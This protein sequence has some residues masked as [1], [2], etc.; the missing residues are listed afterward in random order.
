M[1]DPRR[2]I[3]RSGT[4]VALL[5]AGG[6]IAG[7]CAPA[8]LRPL[9]PVDARDALARI[10]DNFERIRGPL[11]GS[12]ARISAR[13]RDQ[14][15]TTRRFTGYDA[16]LIFGAPRCLYL[17]IKHPAIGSVARIGSND[18]RYWL[19]IDVDDYRNLM[20]GTWKALEAG[21]SRPLTVPPNR[22][23]DTLLLRPLDEQLPRGL[24]PLLVR[25]EPGPQQLLFQKRD[26]F[27]WPY[28]ARRI[29]L[30][31]SAPF[32]PAEIIDYQPDGNVA[33]HAK[34]SGYARVRD[35]GPDGPYTARRYEMDFSLEDAEMTL[36]LPEVRYRTKD[37]PFCEF[38]DE[39][40]GPSDYL[41]EPEFPTAANPPNEGPPNQ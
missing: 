41:D 32:L 4:G 8:N 23:L 14:D 38:P 12:G 29:I 13:F 25:V 7:G 5:M 34:L 26:G 6:L 35:T 9:A 39:W 24:P 17:D 18:R 3:R 16:T 2:R 27:G 11:S 10:N 22:L 37:Y 21:H 31:D 33:M 20:W 1:A 30:R 15:G 28:V 19:T 36:D 40:V